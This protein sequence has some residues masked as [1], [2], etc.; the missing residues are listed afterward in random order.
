MDAQL[1]Q[2]LKNISSLNVPDPDIQQNLEDF[3]SFITRTAQNQ[4]N[5]MGQTCSIQ[6]WIC[7][8]TCEAWTCIFTLPNSPT[9]A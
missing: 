7:R 2:M 3:T 9:R 4:C 6:E 1:H 8:E 5:E